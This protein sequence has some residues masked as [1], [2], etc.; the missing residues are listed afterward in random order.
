MV[1]QKG[2]LYWYQLPP[3]IKRMLGKSKLF[4]YLIS[5]NVAIVQWK[6]LTLV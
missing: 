2:K 5:K 1:A 3:Q 4:R 6:E